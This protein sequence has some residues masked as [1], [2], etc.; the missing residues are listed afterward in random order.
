LVP[1]TTDDDFTRNFTNPSS[2]KPPP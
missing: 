2:K 1:C